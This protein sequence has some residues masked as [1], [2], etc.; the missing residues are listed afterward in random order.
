MAVI[1]IEVVFDF[2]C[3]WCYIGKRKLDKAIALY[4]K[5]Y[6]GGRY[7][8]I[9]IKWIPY[10]LNYNPHSH[11]VPKSE[12]VDERLKDMKPEQREGLFKRMDQIGRSIGIHF[13]GGGLI[14]PDTRDAHRLVHLSRC[15]PQDVQNELVEK[16]LEAYHEHEKDISSTEVLKEIAIGVGLNVEEVEEWLKSGIAVEAVNEEA[17]RSKEGSDNTGVPRYN[18][19]GVYRLD[20]ATDPSEF[21]EIFGKVKKGEGQI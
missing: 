3:A 15:K 14:G 8:T 13:N 12:L 6:P 19:Q 20:G 9:S 4:Q 5:V 10:Y 2:V 21:M 17:E 11:S 16:I 18:I 1:E 7:D